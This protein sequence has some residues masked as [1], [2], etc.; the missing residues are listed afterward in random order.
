MLCGDLLKLFERSRQE[1]IDGVHADS[2]LI[3]NLSVLHCLHTTTYAYDAA[4]DLTEVSRGIVSVQYGYNNARNRVSATDGNGN[5]TTLQYDSRQRLHT[6]SFADETHQTINYDSADNVTSV[7]DQASHTTD[8]GYDAT[9]HLTS[10]TQANSPFTSANTVNYCRDGLGNLAWVEDAN[11]HYTSQT[12]DALGRPVSLTF[13]DGTNGLAASYDGN[14]NLVSL[15]KTS[16][17]GVKTATFGYDSL[18]PLASETPDAS[19]GEPTVSATYTANACSPALPTAP[20]LPTTPTT[21]STGS[22]RSRP[23]PEP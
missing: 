6:I 16:T 19:Y 2:Q 14:S 20:A 8:Y 18:N 13:P 10:V 12:S 4:G 9:N 7:V 5:V 23:R 17:A 3:R 22:S 15:G 11:G 1:C 21:P